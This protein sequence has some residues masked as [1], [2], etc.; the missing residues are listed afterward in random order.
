[1]V[2]VC[3]CVGGGGVE[4]CSEN[5]RKTFPRHFSCSGVHSDVSL[6]SKKDFRGPW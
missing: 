6:P 2:Y 4:R 5:G 1:M 3:V